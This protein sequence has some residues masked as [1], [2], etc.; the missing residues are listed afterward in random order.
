MWPTESQFVVGDKTGV[1]KA[2]KQNKFG[3]AAFLPT[4]MPEFSH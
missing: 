1:E 3:F 4:V 2:G